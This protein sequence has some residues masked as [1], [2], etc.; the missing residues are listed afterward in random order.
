MARQKKKKRMKITLNLSTVLIQED[1]HL[2]TEVSSSSCGVLRVFSDEVLLI[3][4]EI[5][6]NLLFLDILRKGPY[7]CNDVLSYFE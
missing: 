6:G 1:M 3:H 2:S 4:S 7:I 5:T